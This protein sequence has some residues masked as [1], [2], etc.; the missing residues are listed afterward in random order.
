MSLLSAKTPFDSQTLPDNILQRFFVDNSSGG[1]RISPWHDI[2]LFSD[3][4]VDLIHTISC[5]SR[6]SKAFHR[7]AKELPYNHLVH[8]KP[9][10]LASPCDQG[11]APQTWQCPTSVDPITGFLGC[12]EPLDVVE[13][14]YPSPTSS[15]GDVY[16]VRV[17]GALPLVRKGVTCWKVSFFMQ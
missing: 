16:P 2:P 17:I 10:P 14:G 9:C 3:N 15:P 6:G 7:I 12:G 5:V 1:K 4:K 11:V 8:E 13:L